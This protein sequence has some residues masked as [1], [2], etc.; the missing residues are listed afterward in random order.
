MS[1]RKVYHVAP[2]RNRWE[3][4]AEGAQRATRVH[5]TK[6]KAVAAARE[7]AKKQTP[8]QLIVH[9]LDGSVQ[10]QFTFEE[11]TERSESVFGCMRGTARINGDIV[12]PMWEEWN[13]E[14]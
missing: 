1:T 5:D 2:S 12:S 7:L 8:S 6:E 11:Q 3:I 13:A 9:K 14:R 4:K 10:R